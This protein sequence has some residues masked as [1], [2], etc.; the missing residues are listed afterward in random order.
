MAAEM[1]SG[2]LRLP[3]AYWKHS[4]GSQVL[5]WECEVSDWQQVLPS[6]GGRELQGVLARSEIGL[7]AQEPILGPP[8]PLAHIHVQTF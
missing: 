6:M 5:V 7:H 3:V 1:C 2:L 8:S 4:T